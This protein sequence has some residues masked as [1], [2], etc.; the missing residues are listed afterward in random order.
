MVRVCLLV[1][2]EKE[3]LKTAG[4]DSYLKGDIAS[5]L[6]IYWKNTNVIYPF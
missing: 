4:G 5:T 6:E 1:T 3:V 2:A